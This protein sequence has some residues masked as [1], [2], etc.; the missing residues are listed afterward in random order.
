MDNAAYFREKAQQ[1]RE[2]LKV[3]AAPAVI[4]QL[5]MWIQEFEDQAEAIEGH[6]RRA[7]ST[8]DLP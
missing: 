3:A 4:M 6:G 7:V 2:L 1:C 5:Q 8:A